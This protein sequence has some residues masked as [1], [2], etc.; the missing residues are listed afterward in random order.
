MIN[1]NNPSVP[2]NQ[3]KKSEKKTNAFKLPGL[4]L[5]MSFKYI[6]LVIMDIFVYAFKGIKFFCFDIFVLLF[7]KNPK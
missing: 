6:F 2:T 3:E 7:H 5:F 4:G 1:E